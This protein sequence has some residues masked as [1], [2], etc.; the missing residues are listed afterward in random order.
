VRLLLGSLV[1]LLA[2]AA[3]HWWLGERSGAG[4]DLLVLRDGPVDLEPWPDGLRAEGGGWRWDHVVTGMQLLI[5]KANNPDEEFVMLDPVTVPDAKT[6]LVD[7]RVGNV[8]T[9]ERAMVLSMDDH[10]TRIAVNE[11]ELAKKGDVW[12]HTGFLQNGVR[13]PFEIAKLEFRDAQDH[14]IARYQNPDMGRRVR[15]R[16]RFTGRAATTR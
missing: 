8:R 6:L 4:Q 2:G 3:G 14:V 16:L 15:F 10:G 13:K 5:A 12:V 1:L 9:V 7:F 11:G